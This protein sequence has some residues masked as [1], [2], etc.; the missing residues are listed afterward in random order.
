M[1][2][3][4]APRPHARAVPQTNAPSPWPS[5]AA[6]AACFLVYAALSP[7][8]AGDKDSGEFALVLATHGLAH[9]TGYPLYTLLG[10]GFVQVAHALGASWAQAANLFSALGGGI[11]MGALHALA[12]RLLP[13]RAGPRAAAAVAVL[14]LLAFGFNP[15]WTLE[16]TLA[17]V[18]S[19]HV[20]W[21]GVA[22]LVS[23]RVLESLAIGRPRARPFALWGAVVGAGLAH[24]LTSV[25]FAAPLTLAIGLSLRRARAPGDRGRVLLASAA[26][27]AIPLATLSYVAWR[28]WHP[29]VVQ[30]PELGPGWTDVFDHVTGAQYRAFLGRFAPSAVQ[31]AHLAAHIYPWLVPALLG[32]LA[33]LLDRADDRHAWRKALGAGVLLQV[34]Y[35]FLYGV[36]DPATYF[37]P[38]LAVGLP[39]FVAA[40]AGRGVMRRR[41]RA[42]ALAAALALAVPAAAGGRTALARN[43][44]FARFDDRLRRM[45]AA[46]PPGR[47]F[48][49]WDDD[50]AW[51]L[52]ALQVLEGRR[53][54]VEVVQPRHLTHGVP[55]AR[56]RA[57]HGFDPVAGLAPGQLAS[58]QGDDA[59]SAAL[60]DAIV[61][62]I[63]E[64]RRAP[65]V[66]FRPDVPS[67]RLLTGPE[68][69]PDSVRDGVP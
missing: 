66:L 27:A 31:R 51:R 29:A 24:H 48:V 2:S 47:A 11:A 59:R 33:A 28:A 20:A 7:G 43:E 1:T 57:R 26:G 50:M 62:R 37:L 4:V 30:W 63:H 25:L 9:P 64:A 17:E 65:V 36:S 54:D 49:V 15:L 16:T 40:V 56:F 52:V 19:W 32:A 44:A 67:L 53:R 13:P 10:G 68:S 55:R 35:S 18:N 8:V 38:A 6:G 45:W 5:M 23:H 41:G 69:P 46:L 60:V 42:V 39:L 34:A 22:A 14:P 12:A 58:A 21:V 3:R 61:M